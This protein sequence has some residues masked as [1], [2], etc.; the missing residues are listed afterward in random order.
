[1]IH[2]FACSSHIAATVQRQTTDPEEQREKLYYRLT[3]LDEVTE[4]CWYLL[5]L[6]YNQCWGSATFWMTKIF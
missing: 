1:M 4:W 2:S 5:E 3:M 6:I